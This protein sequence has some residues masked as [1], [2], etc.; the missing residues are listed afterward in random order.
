ML[1]NYLYLNGPSILGCWEGRTIASVCSSLTN[2]DIE[3]W[4]LLPASCEALVERKVRA[5][6]V[7]AAY[8][9]VLWLVVGSLLPS[10][11]ALLAQGKHSHRLVR[12]PRLYLGK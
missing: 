4:H 11:F 2:V 6:E 5:V 8:G 10:V 1:L 3:V 7:F 9:V 12:G